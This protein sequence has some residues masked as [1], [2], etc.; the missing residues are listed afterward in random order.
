MNDSELDALLFQ[1]VSRKKSLRTI[2]S[3]LNKT[4]YWVNKTLT[5][6]A[7]KREVNIAGGV[8]DGTWAVICEYLEPST[9]AKF[10]ARDREKIE[11]WIDEYSLE[12]LKSDGDRKIATLKNCANQ[13]RRDTI[14]V[15]SADE[16]EAENYVQIISSAS[17]SS[18][19]ESETLP[20]KEHPRAWEIR[21]AIGVPDVI[22]ALKNESLE[23]K[24]PVVSSLK[25]KALD[26]SLELKEIL[27]YKPFPTD[28][29]MKI[30]A[31]ILA[32]IGIKLRSKRLR[33]GPKCLRLYTID[34][35]CVES[36]LDYLN[37]ISC[38]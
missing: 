29:G 8:G 30:T 2:A 14:G 35:N 24:N 36:V 38:A 34:S 17:D 28:S 11:K 1:W 16:L 9:M 7:F 10:S 37:R 3:E 22:I 33:R 18:T 5:A 32:Q 4:K 12:L 6:H 26:H 23:S 21:R 13:S 27:N 20:L 25:R 31:E 19:L 15:K